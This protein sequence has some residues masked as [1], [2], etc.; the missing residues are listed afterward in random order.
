[1]FALGGVATHVH[2][3][4]AAD[5]EG[6]HRVQIDD[7]AE[8]SEVVRAVIAIRAAAQG[9]AAAG[10]RHRDV[11]AAEVRNR[12]LQNGFGR[13]EVGDLDRVEVI[14]TGVL[15]IEDG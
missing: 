5:V 7:G 3:R 1:V 11:P 13:V 14:T 10:G 2:R 9:R 6:G 12:L 4:Q 8:G 15:L